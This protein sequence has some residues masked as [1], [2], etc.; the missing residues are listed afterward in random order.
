MEM[1]WISVE[2]SLPVIPEGDYA[3]SVLV[4]SY[5]P[6]YNEL[7]NKGYMVQSVLYGKWD[8]SVLFKKAEKDGFMTLYFGEDVCWGPVSDLV[9]HWMYLPE[10]PE[11]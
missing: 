7:T 11:I 10:P 4:V 9:T 1:K 2:D 5:D 3:V 6:I 8:K